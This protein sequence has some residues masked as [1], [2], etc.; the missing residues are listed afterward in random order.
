[1]EKPTTNTSQILRE[2]PFPE[3]HYRDLKI[4]SRST[5]QRWEAQGLRV[6]KIGGRRFIY[7]DEL[8]AFLEGQAARSCETDEAATGAVHDAR[9]RGGKVHPRIS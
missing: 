1:M 6:L 2:L 4:G 8:V 3:K 5:F 7:Q 9:T